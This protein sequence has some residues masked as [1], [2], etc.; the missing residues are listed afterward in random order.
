VN[1]SKMWHS[2]VHSLPRSS[3][4]GRIVVLSSGSAALL[5]PAISVRIIGVYGLVVVLL[6]LAL[7][8]L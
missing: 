5:R 8:L 1:I 2:L 4:P 6:W 7:F 3:T